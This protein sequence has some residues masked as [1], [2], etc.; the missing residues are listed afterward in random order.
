MAHK[1]LIMDYG[2]GDVVMS[3]SLIRCMKK[4]YPEHK[5]IVACIYSD[6]LRF[7][8]NIDHLYQL[9]TLNDMYT[10][11]V[12]PLKDS[13][14]YIML[15]PYEPRIQWF[16][17]EPMSKLFCDLAGVEWDNDVLEFYL[18]KEE[19]KFGKDLLMCCTKPV[20]ALQIESARVSLRGGEKMITE[21]DWFNENWDATVDALK[22]DYDFVQVGGKDEYRVKNTKMCLLG[23]TNYRE[24]AAVLKNCHT[25]ITIDSAVSHIGPAVGKTGIVLFGRSKISTLGHKYNTNIEIK[26]TCPDQPCLRPEPASGDLELRDGNNLANWTC[27]DRVCMKIITPEIVIDAIKNFKPGKIE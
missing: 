1:V 6:I 11:W 2:V 14:D 4:Q 22:K 26:S 15:K 18:T 20:I 16:G 27:K 17:N 24:S 7:N 5:L 19:E 21:K 9:G 10:A 23:K 8:P 25:F 3:T 13:K 12:R